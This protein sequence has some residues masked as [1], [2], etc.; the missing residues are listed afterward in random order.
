MQSVG[1][2]AAA[3]AD[4]P[5]HSAAPRHCAVVGAGAA[6]LAAA[7]VLRAAGHV[8]TVFDKGRKVGGRMALRETAQGAFDHGTPCF[9]ADLLASAASAHITPWPS[10]AAGSFTGVPTMQQLAQ[11]WASGFEVRL[12]QHVE[13]LT[14]AGS[15]WHV[16]LRDAPT[17][18]AFDAVVITV[19]QPQ[20]APLLPDTELP[21]V[22]SRISY[23]PCWTLLWTP[24]ATPLP[25]TPYASG[26]DHAALHTLIRED[27]KPARSGPPRYVIH[28]RADWSRQWLES[29]AEVVAAMLQQ[30]AAAWLGIAPD[31]HHLAVH[32]WRYAQVQQ[33]LGAAQCTLAPGLHYASDGCLG[34]GIRGAIASGEAAAH[35]L[36][37]TF[38]LAVA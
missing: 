6:G 27:L 33:A 25:P 31:A 29:P 26:I 4:T 13:R 8:V 19:P 16:G 9:H 18:L 5:L 14:P 11:H 10:Q 37:H 24:S 2:L 38:E 32:R 20:L 3:R 21:T 7:R 30:Q 15:R 1:G 36:L 22:L 17:T 12:S 23:D 34:D 28:A 35:A